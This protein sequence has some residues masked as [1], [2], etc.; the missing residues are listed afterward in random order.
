MS[1]D[2]SEFDCARATVFDS[3]ADEWDHRVTPPSA[4][5][6]SQLIDS[7]EIDGKTVLD[8]GSGTGVLLSAVAGRSPKKWIACDLSQRMLEILR[9]RYEGKIAGLVTLQADA[10]SLPLRDD[11]VDVVLCNGVY[12]HF[13]DKRRALSEIR[14]VLRPSGVL[15]INHFVCRDRVNSIHG[16]SENEVLRVDL[17]PPAIELVELLNS[18][19]FTA[20][21]YTDT[22]DL[23]R[24]RA[25]LP[26][27]KRRW[28]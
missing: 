13:H 18:I 10:H 25:T 20:S 7:I 27:P 9:E 24:I 6:L 26:T 14:R 21:H 23:Y 19:G 1:C 11:N 8:I 12:P 5:A 15:I 3:L 17:L 16:S 2:N 22:D 28:N 4:E